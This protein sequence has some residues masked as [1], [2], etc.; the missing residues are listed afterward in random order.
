M[1]IN[2]K[3][4]PFW[5][6]LIFTLPWVTVWLGFYIF[7]PPPDPGWSPKLIL[8][9]AGVLLVPPLCLFLLLR[10]VLWF[11]SAFKRVG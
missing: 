3:G 8:I 6:W 7:F 11:I 10:L 5:V 9:C 4:W 2:I 1:A